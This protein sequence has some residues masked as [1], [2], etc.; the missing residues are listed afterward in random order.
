MTIDQETNKI[1][2]IIKN[3]TV[4]YLSNVLKCDICASYSIRPIFNQFYVFFHYDIDEHFYCNERLLYIINGRVPLHRVAAYIE[5][6][7]LLSSL[8]I[9]PVHRLIVIPERL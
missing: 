2:N 1:N 4:D 3:A 7:F 8:A 6:H 9:V 5:C